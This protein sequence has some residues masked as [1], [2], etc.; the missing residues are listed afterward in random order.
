MTDLERIRGMVDLAIDQE[1]E[2]IDDREDCPW[3]DLLT[4][5][6]YAR[7]EGKDGFIELE[8]GRRFR[9]AVITQD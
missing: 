3:V 1:L 9:I 6:G 2:A 5:S 4:G 7:E 8:D